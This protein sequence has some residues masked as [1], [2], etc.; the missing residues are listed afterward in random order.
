MLNSIST[1]VQR[2]LFVSSLAMSSRSS[3]ETAGRLEVRPKFTHLSSVVQSKPD[4]MH[5]PG[6][7][8]LAKSVKIGQVEVEPLSLHAQYSGNT[9]KLTLKF[10]VDRVRQSGPDGYDSEDDLPVIF[11]RPVWVTARPEEIFQSLSLFLL[12]ETKYFFCCFLLLSLISYC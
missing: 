4:N 5:R 2:R 8:A 3:R 12:Q 9:S 6:F 10:E 1:R 11:D 7:P